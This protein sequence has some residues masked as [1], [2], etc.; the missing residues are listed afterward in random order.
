MVDC[1]VRGHDPPS[2][3]VFSRALD[4]VKDEHVNETTGGFELQPELLL[5]RPVA[6]SAK[7]SATQSF[8]P[9]A[10]ANQQMLTTDRE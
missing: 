6:V 2:M 4:M 5:K 8:R 10:T 3:S 7:K 9:F 1:G